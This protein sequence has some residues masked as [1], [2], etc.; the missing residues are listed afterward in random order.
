MGSLLYPSRNDFEDDNDKGGEGRGR[1]GQKE[2]VNEVRERG[3][4]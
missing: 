3:Q 1:T 4:R 2:N